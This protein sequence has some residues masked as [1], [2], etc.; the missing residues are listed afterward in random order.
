MVLS[1]FFSCLL[2]N[3]T[4]NLGEAKKITDQFKIRMKLITQ[5][6][7]ISDEL[8]EENNPVLFDSLSKSGEEFFGS[9][10]AYGISSTEDVQELYDWFS[11]E[12]CLEKKE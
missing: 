2:T 6:K 8:H 3:F 1:R 7:K 12:Y 9:L 10:E 4:D 11:Q 5:L